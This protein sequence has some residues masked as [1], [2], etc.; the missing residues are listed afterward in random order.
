MNQNGRETLNR[1]SVFTFIKHRGKPGDANNY[2]NALNGIY[3][4]KKFS[5]LHL[6]LWNLKTI[7]KCHHSS[8]CFCKI[9]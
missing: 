9:Q 6:T 5:S 1:H 4:K 2:T 3:N 8:I 7:F